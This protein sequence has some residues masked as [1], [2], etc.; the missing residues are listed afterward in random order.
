[1]S[2]PASASLNSKSCPS[3]TGNFSL[4]FPNSRCFKMLI[5]SRN[6]LISDSYCR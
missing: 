2:I 1:V 3:P 5:S 4:L 6:S